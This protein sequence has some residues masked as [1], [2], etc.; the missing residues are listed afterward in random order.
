M[1]CRTI[2]FCSS[3]CITITIQVTESHKYL[4]QGP[5]ISHPCFSVL[6]SEPSMYDSQGWAVVVPC[7]S[8]SSSS[9]SSN[10]NNYYY[11]FI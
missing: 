6:A 9:S 4:P 10:N 7:S 1:F 3:D 11:L 2:T 8:S 5:H